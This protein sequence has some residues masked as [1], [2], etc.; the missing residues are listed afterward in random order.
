M[1]VAGSRLKDLI[2]SDLVR[3]VGV[4]ARESRARGI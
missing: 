3:S 2:K 1:L 4:A